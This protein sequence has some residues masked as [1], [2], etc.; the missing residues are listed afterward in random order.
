MF[1]KEAEKFMERVFPYDDET[2]M[3][4][5]EQVKGLLARFAES[6]YNEAKEILQLFIGVDGIDDFIEV[7]DKAEQF[8]KEKE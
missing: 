2:P 3:Y 8:L 7:R 1:E 6:V 4:G 5:E